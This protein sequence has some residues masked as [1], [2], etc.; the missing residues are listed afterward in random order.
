[1]LA[2]PDIFFAGV[3]EQRSQQD[4]GLIESPQRK[5]TL[6]WNPNGELSALD[7]ARVINLFTNH[8][9]KRCDLG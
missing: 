8:E 3:S 2:P 7:M 6:K 4:S 9:L 5:T 1:L